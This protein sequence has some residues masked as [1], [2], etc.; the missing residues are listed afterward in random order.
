MKKAIIVT[1]IIVGITLLSGCDY[2]YYI[3]G[4]GPIVTET[5][6][7]DAFT[8][9]NMLGAEDVEISYGDVQEVT[10]SGQANIIARIKTKVY[11]DTWDMELERGRYR[12]YDLKYF[13]TLPRINTIKND[14]AARVVV[15]DFINEGDLDITIN[16]AGDV[17]LNRL[18]NTENLFIAIDGLGH[19]ECRDEMPSL[20]Y[21]DIYITGS[22]DFKGYPAETKNCVID[23]DGAA[24]CEVS[25]EAELQV[26]IDGSGVVHYKG[27][28]SISQ[29]ISGLGVVENR[30]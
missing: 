30:N 12:N 20:Q 11:G 7:L 6:E 13:I 10:V 2:G 3:V 26:H 14:G 5:L 1:G 21:L 8:G 28:P 9:I 15:N 16:G 18:E 24:T 19:I 22:G 23:I 27:N 25:V 17:T 4:E 29:Q